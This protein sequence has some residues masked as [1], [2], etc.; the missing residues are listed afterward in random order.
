MK[1][2]SRLQIKVAM[3]N[4]SNINIP[5]VEKPSQLPLELECINNNCH[6]VEQDKVIMK[7]I[8]DHSSADQRGYV[9]YPA[10]NL[11]DQMGEI[12]E[13]TKNYEV[14]SSRCL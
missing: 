11:L 7:Y 6:I 8:P 10:I 5:L 4:I 1:E 3:E 13:A 9:Y 14:A 2:I 12:I